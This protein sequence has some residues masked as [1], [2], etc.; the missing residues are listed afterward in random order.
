MFYQRLL[1]LSDDALSIG[2]LP[3]AEVQAGLDE[4]ERRAGR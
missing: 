2:N 4:L 3:R 1:G